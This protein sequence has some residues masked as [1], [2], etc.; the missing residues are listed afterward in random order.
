MGKVARSLEAKARR[1]QPEMD[2]LRG[3]A[4]KL[5]YKALQEATE[6]TLYS[7]TPRKVTRNMLRSIRPR[8]LGNKGAAVGYDTT[9]A[10]YA[11]RRLKMKGPYK[12]H[13]GEKLMEPAKW[14][15]EHKAE[16]LH[17]LGFNALKRITR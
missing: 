16:E 14:I 6:A 13:G 17:R 10:P 4:A 1:V 8:V 3:D 12:G 15:K 5:L 9:A 7:K 11:V 2:R